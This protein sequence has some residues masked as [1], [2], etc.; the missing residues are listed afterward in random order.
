MI[1]PRISNGVVWPS[2]QEQPI[3]MPR[4]MLRD[5]PAIIDTATTWSASV[6]CF[7]PSRKPRV[8][9]A[10]VVLGSTSIAE[11]LPLL[12]GYCGNCHFSNPKKGCLRRT[13]S[14][15][16]RRLNWESKFGVMI[17]ELSNFCQLTWGFETNIH[18]RNSLR[19]STL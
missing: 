1:T 4:Q 3:H 18:I 19:S 14:F 17:S 8:S 2:P 16:R 9:A 6:A 15:W 13:Y 11:L 7:S 12:I 5:S 10:S